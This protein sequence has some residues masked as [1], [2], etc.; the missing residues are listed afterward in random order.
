MEQ[1]KLEIGEINFFGFQYLYETSQKLISIKLKEFLKI[2]LLTYSLKKSTF[3]LNQKT[4]NIS[5]AKKTNSGYIVTIARVLAI[6]YQNF[7]NS[8]LKWQ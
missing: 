4:E 8:T 3:Y 2:Q 6:F 5:D 7:V 1:H